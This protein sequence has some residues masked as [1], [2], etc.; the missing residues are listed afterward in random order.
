MLCEACQ[1]EVSP[2]GLEYTPE[3]QALCRPCR[4]A[5]L[6]RV[7]EQDALASGEY[8]R[9]RCGALLS[10]TGDP[11]ATPYLGPGELDLGYFFQSDVYECDSCGTN[12]KVQHGVMVSLLVTVFGGFSYLA[13]RA[14][15]DVFVAWLVLLI[16]MAAILGYDIY[17]R[18]RYPRVWSKE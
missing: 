8:R 1:T 4:V 17:C 2:E 13:A 15:R 16:P 10:P 9:C 7:A 14:G 3:G 18:I 12:F 5:Y 6:S 11:S